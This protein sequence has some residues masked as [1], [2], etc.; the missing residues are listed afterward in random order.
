M[1]CVS[2]ELGAA[3]SGN[4]SRFVIDCKSAAIDEVEVSMDSSVLQSIINRTF[5]NPECGKVALDAYNE[6]GY[7][8]AALPGTEELSIGLCGTN[9]DGDICYQLYGLGLDLVSS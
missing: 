3:F 8:D 6:C 5:C 1:Q 4:N 2:N 9:N 7:F